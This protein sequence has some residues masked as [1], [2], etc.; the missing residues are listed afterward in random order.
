MKLDVSPLGSGSR[1]LRA[2]VSNFQGVGQNSLVQA[3]AQD[4]NEFMLLENILPPVDG[5]LR[6]RW[7]YELFSATNFAGRAMFEY[8][9]DTAGHRRIVVSSSTNVKG[10]NEDGTVTEGAVFTPSASLATPRMVSSRDYGYF[11]PGDANGPRKWNSSP[12]VTTNWGIRLTGTSTALTLAGTGADDS[13]SGTIAWTNPGNITASD[14]TRATVT[15]AI[16]E[17]SHWL[18]ATN[19]GFTV[20]ADARVIGIAVEV[21]GY[22]S[23]TNDADTNFRLVVN[24]VPLAGSEKVYETN[25]G[26]GTG[27]D[28]T[29]T[30]GSESDTWGTQLSPAVVNASTFGVGIQLENPTD[31][32]ATWNVD[33]VKIRV[34]YVD[35]ITIGAPSAGA[36]TLTV[37]RKYTYAYRNSVTGHISNFA[38][39]SAST[40]PITTDDIPLSGIPQSSDTQV[41]RVLILA[42]SDGGGEDALYFLADIPNG[43]ST[44]TDNITEEELLARNVYHEIDALGFERGCAEN[45]PPPV[46]GLLPTKHRGRLYLADGQT[47]RFSKGIS[48]VTTST[49][50]I[51]G[52]YEE[53]WPGDY[54]MDISEG[55]ESIT[56]L[57]SDGLY[58]YIGTEKHI[59]R[60]E[61]DGPENFRNPDILFNSVG[62]L[63]QDVLQTVFLDGRPVGAMWLTPDFRVVGSDFVVYQDVGA[64][65]Q[66]VLDSISWS[67]RLNARAMYANDG[68]YDFYMLAIPT[69]AGGLSNC[70][71]WCIYDLGSKK[72]FIWKPTLQGTTACLFNVQQTN[73]TPQA[74]FVANNNVYRWN[75]SLTQDAGSNF[76]ATIKTSWTDLGDPMSRKVLNELDL[77]TGDSAL[78]VSIEGASTHAEFASPASVVSSS[79]L[80]TSPLGDYKVYLAGST[81]KDRFY[82]FT[83]VSP[84]S[85]STAALLSG[86]SLEFA[87]IHRL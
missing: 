7:G 69:G 22:R 72:W 6:R 24:D 37:G 33:A 80:S 45:D 63:N 20:P 71:T 4:P 39:L 57:F 1:N 19:F 66:D 3:P 5:I 76:A 59:R 38:P 87:P 34:Y 9:N 40:G 26:F 61:G 21:E 60:L 62:V 12:S 23:N 42:T 43:T 58:L 30:V 77:L 54:Q 64:P 28:A 44:L 68:A 83:F 35:T 11:A 50:T 15:L 2:T 41:D 16:G 32:G 18:R 49:G 75:S 29:F 65:I 74:L 46:D 10:L 47:L 56:A 36:V 14:N 81:S 73:G 79:A 52:R 31:F 67:D 84:S 48:E 8:E 17:T 27:S 85:V 70:D 86:F 55:A 78:Q 51:A 82:R 25:P 13:T 53:C